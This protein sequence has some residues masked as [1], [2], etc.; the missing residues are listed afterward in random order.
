MNGQVHVHVLCP[1]FVPTGINQSERNR[2]A[3]LADTGA[4]PTRSQIVGRAMGDKAVGGGKMTASA[5]ASLV[6]EA[7][8]ENRFYVFSHPHALGGVRLRMEDVLARRN[9]TDPFIERPHVGR[10]LRAALRET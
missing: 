6:F 8:D 3:E 10:E 4:Q 1:Y 5:V 9:P 2:P 7:M